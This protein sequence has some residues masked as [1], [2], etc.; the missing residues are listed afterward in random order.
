M[1]AARTVGGPA[2]L[3]ILEELDKE[4]AKEIEDFDRAVDVEALGL[5]KKIGEHALSQSSDNLF[6]AFW[7]SASRARTSRARAIVQVA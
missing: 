3:E 5:A 4:L 7:C 6:T 2:Y 1:T